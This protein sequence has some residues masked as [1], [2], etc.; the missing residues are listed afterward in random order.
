QR[1]EIGLIR[2]IC[3]KERSS[4]QRKELF[5]KI[6]LRE[7][8]DHVPKKVA[9]QLLMDMKV[10]WSSTYVML[11]RAEQKSL[12]KYDVDYF[13]GRLG[14]AEKDPQKRRKITDLELTTSEWDRVKL[15]L[16]L[17]SHADM[18]QHAFSTDQGPMLHLALPAL[19]A[20]WKAWSSRLHREKYSDFKAGLRAGINK[21]TDYYE[22]TADSDAYIM[23]MLLDPSQKT[24]HIR[25]YWGD[26][27]LAE[28]LMHAED[29]E[30][31]REIYA[32]T[33]PSAMNF[34][35]TR[36]NQTTQRQRLNRLMRELSDD[37]DSDIPT[38]VLFDPARPWLQEYHGYLD[39]KDH[40]GGLS[41]V[42]WWGINASRYPVWASL[43]RDFLSIMATSV[44]SERAFSSAGITISKRRNR[45][46]ADIVEALQCLKCM[47]K[48]NLMFREADDPTVSGE[49]QLVSN[50]T[51]D[52]DGWDKMVTDLAEDELDSETEEL[53]DDTDIDILFAGGFE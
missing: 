24:E 32:N 34:S 39:S 27:L 47:I 42:K 10:R 50:K 15:L 11:E 41:I 12:K 33:S 45:L 6:Q 38:P 46:K 37:E 36:T 2:A 43:S 3:I 4:A 20:L 26:E 52:S 48:R 17:L 9:K 31:Y 18:A 8:D 21:V 16:D 19:E 44:S 53:L 30:R 13:I 40:L 25:K 28:A 49:R 7:E 35:K 5:K 1:D 23:A 51:Q 14:L 29:L 22:K